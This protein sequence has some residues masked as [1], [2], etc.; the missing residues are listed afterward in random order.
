MKHL[1]VSGSERL[2]GEVHI[3]GA[4]NSV[5]PILAATVLHGGISILEG[6][7][8]LSDVET[9][10]NILEYLGAKTCWQGHTLTVDT[11]RLDR[12]AVPEHLMRQMRSSVIF[13]G[14]LLARFGEAELFYPGGCELGPRPIDLHLRA[15]GEL[16]AEITVEGG[17]IRA[18]AKKL[19]ATEITLDIPSVGATENAILAAVGA[20][21]V[22]V[23]RN[24]AREPEIWDLQRF[25]K[26]LGVNIRGGGS[27]SITVEG[28]ADLHD[29][30]HKVMPD[31]IVAATYLCACAACGGEVRLGGAEENRL[32]TVLA[33][34]RA[35]GCEIV[36]DRE[37]ITLS[38]E[39]PLL[40]VPPVRTAIY[41]GFPTDAQ[42][43]L[44]AALLKS[45]GATVFVE[46]IFENRYRHVDELTRLGADIRVE[47]RVAV[48][49]GVEKLCGADLRCTDLRGGAALAIAALSAEG[50]S[51]LHEIY[52]IE[53]GYEDLT[54]DLTAL[55]AKVRRVIEKD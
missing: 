36:C 16:G 26:S 37:G 29:G 12:C 47:G 53:R 19:R 38:R 8:H 45:R 46:N 31:R 17:G 33:P 35:A 50:E 43:V 11:S 55:G 15:L 6:C 48:V 20:E 28:L 13:L 32:L 30:H 21:G 7:P 1:L 24:A 18:K 51:T 27:S 2:R 4:K 40:A 23:I 42:A 34:L 49:Y 9:A 52:H 41:P 14:A 10:V 25:L 54:R 39:R 44:M 5:L 3:Q 22:T